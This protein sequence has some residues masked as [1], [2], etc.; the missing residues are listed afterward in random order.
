MKFFALD[1]PPPGVGFDAVIG[2]TLAAARSALGTTTFASVAVT[3]TGVITSVPKEILV[4]EMKFV[5]VIVSEVSS[6][7]TSTLSELIAVIVGTGLSAGWTGVTA[8]LLPPHPR[9]QKQ[10]KQRSKAETAGGMVRR[11]IKPS[12]VYGSQVQAESRSLR[13][14]QLD[15]IFLLICAAPL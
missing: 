4:V 9:D 11:Y 1:A 5:P 12:I 7:P 8:L 10:L 13:F 6:L 15:W 14:E 2:T 3:E